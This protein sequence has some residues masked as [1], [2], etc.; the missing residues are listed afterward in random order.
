MEKSPVQ[1]NSTPASVSSKF[2]RNFVL[3]AIS[4]AIML[5][6]CVALVLYGSWPFALVFGLILILA[7][8]EWVKLSRKLATRH[9]AVAVLVAG[10]L[11]FA[12]NIWS[13]FTLRFDVEH[14]AWLVLFIFIMVWAVDTGAYF[15][16]RLIGGPKLAPKLSPSKTWAGA[17]GGAVAAGAAG[18]LF[19][20]LAGAAQPVMALALAVPV[21]FFAQSGDLLE[22]WLKRKAGVKDA[23]SLIPGH[24]GILDRIDGLLMAVPVFVLF[25]LFFGQ[26]FGW[27]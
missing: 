14:G 16:G 25:Q 26:F 15:S 6:A 23:S 13:I 4:A 7:F 8:D 12:A 9:Q 22:S 5:P 19:A 24:G 1:V 3:R 17:I 2:G 11:Y 10:V 20:D 27:W 18:Y 21:T